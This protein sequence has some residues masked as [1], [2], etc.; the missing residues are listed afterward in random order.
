MK[1]WLN[2]RKVK[3]SEVYIPCYCCIFNRVAHNQLFTGSCLL[4]TLNLRNTDWCFSGY[5]YEN[6]A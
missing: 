5:T 4:R 3:E 2:N 1:I 6:M